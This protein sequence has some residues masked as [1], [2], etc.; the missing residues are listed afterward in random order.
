MDIVLVRKLG[1]PG[2]PELAL[3]ALVDGVQP[4]IV[5][6]DD[7]VE[8][9][10]VPQALIQA[11]AE[12][13][14]M[15]IEQRRKAY[16]G[17]T[18]RASVAGRTVILVDDGMAT[19]VSMRA[20]LRAVR[21]QGATKIVVAVPVAS[22]EAVAEIGNEVDEVIC[23]LAPEL[24]GAVGY[25]YRDFSQVEDDEVVRLLDEARQKEGGPAAKA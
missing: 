19:G 25:Y 1:A 21:R 2:Q 10:G 22:H 12:R 5:L 4:E 7:V 15:T 6:N 8:A 11:E 17:D 3:G 23:P 16:C 13:E 18:P 9:L 20:A 14:L 24:F